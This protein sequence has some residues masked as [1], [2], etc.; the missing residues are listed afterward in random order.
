MGS[1]DIF[2]KRRAERKKRSHDFK[3]PKADPFLI[4][5]EGKKSEPLYLDG[6]RKRILGKAG[7]AVKI[8]EVPT[9]DIHGEGTSTERLIAATEEYVSKARIIYQN[10][11]VVFD[12][13]D[14]V[15]F[16]EAILNGHRKGYSIAWSN[17]CFEYWIFL[18]FSYSDADLHRDEWADKLN[19]LFVQ[20]GIDPDGY[21]KNLENIFDQLDATVGVDTAVRNAKRRMS[22]F[23]EGTDKPS[24][25]APGTMFHSLVE[26]LLA[27]LE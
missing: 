11:W 22:G 15:D 24:G 21:R 10:I 9:I 25:Y 20:Y 27:Y 3:I 6:L 5:T 12:K 14:F 2:K 23:R 7:G 1:D 18:H 17:P 4:V 26:Q 13:D 16:D 8:V 19:G